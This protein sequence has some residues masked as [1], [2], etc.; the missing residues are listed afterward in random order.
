MKKGLFM[1]LKILPTIIS[2]VIIVSIILYLIPE[3]KLTSW[4]GQESGV[5]GYIAAALVGSVSLIQGFIAYP[6]A[7]VLVE[8]GVGYPVIAIFI[9][10]LM[11]VGIM[12]IPVEARYFGMK[13]ALVRNSL[14]FVFA[15]AVG[16]TM[17]V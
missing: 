10:T 12:T 5:M 6:L 13:V 17:G 2:V 7:G 3:Q 14:A 1:F 16:L 8:A 9:T 4:F 11:M 15:L